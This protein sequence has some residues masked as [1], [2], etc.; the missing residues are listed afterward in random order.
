VSTRILLLS[1]ADPHGRPDTN[2][3]DVAAG[4]AAAIAAQPGCE[5]THA[6]VSTTAEIER[7]VRSSRPVAVFNFCEAL[8][9]ESSREPLVPMVLERLG[10]AF[11]GSPAVALRTCLDKWESSEQLR[12][13]G[14]RVPRT[15]RVTSV[16]ELGDELELPA[17]VKPSREDGS[18]GIDAASVVHDMNAL[19]ERVA[20]VLETVGGPVVVQQYVEGRELAI[21]L[22]GD[23]EPRVLPLGE[24]A[25][26]RE[27]L[28]A[29]DVPEI[30]TY[31]SKWDPDAVEYA[32]TKSV[33]AAAPPQL[34][35][36]LAAAG[37]RAF[38]ALGMRDYGR[39]DVRVDAR[40]EPWVIDVNPNC[41]LSR[42]GGFAKAAKRAGLDYDALVGAI[43]RGAL[44]RATETPQPSPTRRV[45]R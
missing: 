23:P 5:V 10:V 15:V 6:V 16:A 35:M 12:R 4:I 42:D 31:A 43:L 13:A 40:G 27:L 7:A 41:D 21:S 20:Y 33:T 32:A 14:I 29:A 44:G 1:A 17:I 26:D 45:E 22:L 36:R 9:G 25:F 8:A 2:V 38:V 18:V 34:A 19:R 28:A 3:D 37:R 11:T 39:V 24:I 30:L